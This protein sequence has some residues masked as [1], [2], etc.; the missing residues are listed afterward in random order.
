[1]YFRLIDWPCHEHEEY[2]SAYDAIDTIIANCSGELGKLMRY[3][4]HYFAYRFFENLILCFLFADKRNHTVVWHRKTMP[5]CIK[6]PLDNSEQPYQ[7][8][9]KQGTCSIVKPIIRA[10]Y[11]EA[12]GLVKAIRGKYLARQI[13]IMP[14]K[15]VII[16]VE[17]GSPNAESAAQI[18]TLL[19]DKGRTTVCITTSCFIH[20]RM[21]SLGESSLLLIHHPRIR[22]SARSKNNTQK[23]CNDYE[24]LK[25]KLTDILDVSSVLDMS[26]DE[27]ASN[28]TATKAIEIIL[29]HIFRLN[30]PSA[31][32]SIGEGY[33][34]MTI[35]AD[36]AMKRKIPTVGLNQ[37][38]IHDSAEYRFF[39]AEH[40][41]FY[42]EQGATI[43]IKNG[44]LKEKTHVVGS[45]IYDR[46]T[47]SM[48]I[49]DR[50]VH[51]LRDWVAGRRTVVI[52]TENRQGQIVEIMTALKILSHF[53][54]VATIIKLHPDDSISEFN[55][56][57]DK[58][59]LNDGCRF[60]I[61]K[62]CNLEELLS[63]ADLLL[64]MYSNII[65]NATLIGTPILVFDPLNVRPLD[66]VGPGVALGA[67]SEEELEQQISKILFDGAH[68][69]AWLTCA[70][71]NIR[72]F[73]GPAD[74][75]A[76]RR[77]ADF[78]LKLLASDGDSNK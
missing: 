59:S 55:A 13:S 56:L 73:A 27:I 61:V 8:K 49:T 44:C 72:K 48:K 23:L 78:L 14:K 63:I 12:S 20:K 30:S 43:A 7:A 68:R 64:T 62:K 71:D 65:I 34:T 38:L 39:P 24:V 40:H 16:L 22:S 74:G 18:A 58:L 60:K 19:R 42:G 45:P 32:L 66:F 28:Y 47:R 26:G 67:F 10:V 52:G 17:G 29:E 50:K 75:G 4:Y 54:G 46:T 3:N 11:R 1:M 5:P 6:G 53:E 33:T 25:K 41:L 76:A 36:L 9:S 37:I 15:A 51:R 77:T 2:Y 21:Q 69:Q 70:R 31:V 57:L 35:C